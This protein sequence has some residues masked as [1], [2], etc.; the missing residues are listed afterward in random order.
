VDRRITARLAAG[1]ALVALVSSTPVALT[2]SP[3]DGMK[4]NALA[5]TQVVSALAIRKLADFRFRQAVPGASAEVIPPSPIGGAAAE[6]TVVGPPHHAYTVSLPREIFLRLLGEAGAARP[7]GVRDFTSYPTVGWG[8]L[9]AEG[10]LSNWFGATRER[11]DDA[12]P[13]GTYAGTYTLTVI[14]P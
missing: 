5:L 8:I 13:P 9:G 4:A 1:S 10:R 11:L 6:L 7:I 3:P 2:A 14:Y 12:Q